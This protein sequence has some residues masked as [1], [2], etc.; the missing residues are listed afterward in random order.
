MMHSRS[1]YGC[2]TCRVRKKKCDENYPIC[3]NCSFRDMKC[4]GYGARPEWM[5]GGERERMVVDDLKQEVKKNLKERK[6]L[7]RTGSSHRLPGPATTYATHLSAE[8]TTVPNFNYASPAS[9]AGETSHIFPSLKHQG[10]AHRAISQDLIL[11]SGTTPSPNTHSKDYE[12]TLLMN[13]LD[14]VFPLQFDC[15]VPPIMELGRGW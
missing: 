11:G 9:T 10:S 6:A 4:Y 7:A 12:S 8:S 2:W 1:H 3:S 13:Y 5:D 15:Y 14:K